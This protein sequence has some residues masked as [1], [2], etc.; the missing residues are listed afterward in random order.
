MHTTNESLARPTPEQLF[1]GWLGRN[2]VVVFFVLLL[3]AVGFVLW[4][5]SVSSSRLVEKTTL[6]DAAIYADS[7]AEFRTLY[8]SEVVTAAKASGMSITHDYK[9][10]ANAIPLPATLSMLLGQRIDEHASGASA[11]LFSEFPFPWRAN[12]GPNDQFERD[13]L[14]HLQ[15]NPDNP[16][17]SFC[18]VD[19]Q[20]VLRYAIADLMRTSCID[21]H[22]SH[23]ESPK[24]DWKVGDVRGVLEVTFPLGNA[25]EAAAENARITISG[26]IGLA[27][28]GIVGM[29]LFVKHSRKTSLSI[30]LS[31][32]KLEEANLR[33]AHRQTELT[34]LL[35]SV[36][37]QR[38]EITESRNV[39]EERSRHVEMARRG[40]LNMMRDMEEAKFKADAAT[41]AKSEFLANMSHEIRTPMTAILGFSE[42]LLNEDGIDLAPEQRRESICTIR[43]NGQYLIDII[44]DI[45]DLS[46]IESGKLEV[47][48][49]D[50]SPYQILAGVVT[51]MSVRSAAKGISLEI[52]FDGPIPDRIQSDPT[53]LRQILINLTG[54]AIKFTEVGKVRIVARLLGANTDQPMMQFDVVDTGIGMTDKQ[55]DILY[56]PFV[57][58]DTSTT[59]KFGGTGLGLTI[60]K[61][62]A[63]MLGGDICAQSTPGKGSTFSVTVCAG[64]LKDV[65]FV[66]NAAEARLSLD[67][68]TKSTATD[69][70]IDCRVLLAEDGPDNQ[71]LIKFVLE[72]GGDEVTIAENGQIAFD[73]ALAAR[74]EGNPFDVILMDMQMPVLDGYDATSKLRASGYSGPIIALTA[75]AM[76]GDKKK[77][78]GAGCDDYTTKPID[79]AELLSLIAQYASQPASLP[80]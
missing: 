64:P 78:L 29:G 19:G 53:R 79:R 57:Q 63:N 75:H 34:T 44:N 73:L 61:R 80:G 10:R 71:R 22:N 35:K 69:V 56:Q 39:T 43:K 31:N 21:C 54:N 40:A 17:Y 38:M 14:S 76:N 36:E 26:I 46:K 77:C 25:T 30:A 20:P 70:R 45:L 67:E 7:L 37:E 60:S 42:M 9:D 8:T 48:Q 15:A 47:E 27:F 16:Y 12:G 74:D 72:K 4:S 18:E 32:R 5:V 68:A 59:R 52:E 55:I 1:M 11:R 41:L 23:P 65:K 28:M 66:A 50:C 24:T 3:T 58:A 13:A 51:L 62:L 2:A 33:L 6:N 49:I